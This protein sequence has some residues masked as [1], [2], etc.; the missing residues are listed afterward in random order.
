MTEL[1]AAELAGVAGVLA[2]AGVA[3][4]GGLNAKLL[5]AGRSNL[6][7]KLWDDDGAAW[8]MRTPPRVGR[9]PS[10]HDVAREYRVTK[11]LATAGVLRRSNAL[12]AYA[13]IG[14]FMALGWCAFPLLGRVSP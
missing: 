12:S 5:T 10:A 2:E 8:V 1:S 7:Y 11:G 13:Y 6:T 3:V 14:V 4:S 9:T